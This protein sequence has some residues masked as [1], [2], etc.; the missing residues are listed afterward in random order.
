MGISADLILYFCMENKYSVYSTTEPYGFYRWG[1]NQMSKFENAYKTV[2]DNYDFREY[3]FSKNLFTKIW[4][5]M[6]RSSLY[7]N[8]TKCVLS[9]RSTV[10]TNQTDFEDYAQIYN[11][12][13][14]LLMYMLWKKIIY[15]S[16]CIAMGMHKQILK[17][18]SKK[19]IETEKINAANF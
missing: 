2:K 11:K 18:K 5:I 13:P 7:Y 1:I 15:R 19:F 9:M 4:G 17:M 10:T 8:F 16:Y 12:K 6:F 14:N 3:V